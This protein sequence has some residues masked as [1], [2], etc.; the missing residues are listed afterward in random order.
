M[1][2]FKPADEHITKPAHSELPLVFMTVLT[3]MSV[4]GFV[5]LFFGE[6]LSLFGFSN[7]ASGNYILAALIMLPAL[8]GLPLSALHLGRPLLAHT[9]MKN[10]RKSWLSREALALGIFAGLGIGVV[11]FYFLELQFFNTIFMIGA[12]IA[13]VYG[14]YSQSMIYRIKARP[15]WDRV[16]TTKRFIGSG[17]LGLILVSLVLT[18]QGYG[19][20]AMVILSLTILMASYQVLV[21]FEEKV[22]FQFLRGQVPGWIKTVVG[23]HYQEIVKS[24]HH[25]IIPQLVYNIFISL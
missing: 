5:A 24:D 6:L 13:G 2:D 12:L 3:Q 21:I 16:S 20:S 8:L 14:I 1:P 25:Q 15:S 7:L 9:A 18:I 10:W 23:L 11:G 4:G 22:F 19:N 17:Y